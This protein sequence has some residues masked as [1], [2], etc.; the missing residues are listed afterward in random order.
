MEIIARPTG[1]LCYGHDNI[2]LFSRQRLLQQSG[3][4]SDIVTSNAEYKAQLWKTSPGVI[5]LCQTLAGEECDYACS[6]AAGHCPESRLLL[7]FT[8]TQKCTPR[9]DYN[10]LNSNDGPGLFS[11][12][13]FNLLY[14]TNTA[15]VS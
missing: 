8:R 12:T 4:P 3:C 6:L 1:V 2:L 7:L 15:L 10:L 11:R 13:V 5:V 9:Q 14:A